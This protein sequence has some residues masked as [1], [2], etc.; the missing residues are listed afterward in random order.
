M[1]PAQAAA[2]RQA[3][4]HLSAAGY[5]VEEVLPPDIE[6]VVQLWHL[7]CVTDVFGGLWPLMQQVGDADGQAS[8]G[9]WLEMHKPADLATY[10]AALTE[11]DGMVLRWLR[12]KG[13]GWRL[14]A[15][16]NGVGAVT[17]AVVLIVVAV[18]KFTEGAWII[19]A[20]IPVLVVH[21]RAVRRHYAMTAVQL[22]LKGFKPRETSRNIVIV[23][24]GGV[25]RAVLRAIEYARSLG[26]DVRVVYVALEGDSSEAVRK[27]WEEW[28]QGLPLIV[29]DSPYRSLIEPLLDYI[30]KVHE[31]NQDAFLTILLP[32]F[33]PRRWWH[34]LLHNQRALLIKGALL[35]TRDIIVTSVPYHLRR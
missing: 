23:P 14:S 15:V 32:E 11:R 17:T 30:K 4:K 26:P 1:H 22:S 33:V 19:L 3:G 12:L 29:L 13:P 6:R 16:V 7:I 25:H 21:F 27:A 2:V 34:H 9:A 31:E 20:W 10:I 5:Q 8:M 24:I 35:F 18:S 28:G